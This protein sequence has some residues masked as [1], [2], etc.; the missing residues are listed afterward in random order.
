MTSSRNRRR[1]AQ[2][3]EA[4]VAAHVAAPVAVVA[5]VHAGAPEAHAGAPEA[6][7]VVLGAEDPEARV[8][9][10]EVHVGAPGEEALPAEEVPSY[11]GREA[12]ALL[13]GDV[14]EGRESLKET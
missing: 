4:H 5:E 14:E 11:G 2:D 7:V 8:A 10:P 13:G 1:R 9:A 6:H 3:V 12:A